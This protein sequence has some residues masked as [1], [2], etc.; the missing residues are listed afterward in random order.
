MKECLICAEELEED[1]LICTQCP[2]QLHFSCAFGTPV[3]NGRTRSMFQNGSF[4]CPVC[5]VSK[6]NDLILQC[7]S[8]NQKYIK[9]SN[10]TQRQPQDDAAPAEERNAAADDSEDML[11]V[12]DAEEVSVV[13]VSDVLNNTDCENDIYAESS[14]CLGGV[15]LTLGS[16]KYPSPPRRYV[17]DRS[18]THRQPRPAANIN[19]LPGL[20]R[21]SAQTAGQAQT[22]PDPTMAPP[23]KLCVEKSKQMLYRLGTLRRSPGHANTFIGGDSHLTKLD[24]KEVDPDDDQVRVRA[25]GGLCIISTVL[26]LLQFK[27]VLHKF[28]KV[29][30]VVG[31]NDALH[32]QDHC[33]DDQGKYLKLLYQ[34]SKRIFPHASI[35]IITPFSGINGISVPYLQNLEET[36]KFV[37][38]KM[39]VVRPPTMR[40][41][42]GIKGVHLSRAGRLAFINFLR[43]NFVKPKQRIFSR[44]SGRSTNTKPQADAPTA[45]VPTPKQHVASQHAN[46]GT[47][48]VP[49]TSVTD[50]NS[51]AQPSYNVCG[52]NQVH[53]Q[54]QSV[55]PDGVS[56]LNTCKPNPLYGHQVRQHDPLFGEHTVR[57]I[58][59]TV[60]NELIKQQQR[61]F[62]NHHPQ[63]W[64]GPFNY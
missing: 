22:L 47:L 40:D 61:M 25:V 11:S 16:P 44:E 46:H 59:A 30:W 60:A 56:V 34:E 51:R 9:A 31:T 50:I 17:Q 2:S 38:P 41:K 58:A 6:N 23:H 64:R 57:D 4:L 35:S 7:V 24:G 1:E 29:A 14:V 5:I 15:N 45:V 18:P 19:G 10:T 37:A 54:P 62:L 63:P 52:D 3:N 33:H 42:I 43:A 27:S 8:T 20:P 55:P 21:A 39:R 49:P 32:I 36:S 26:A 12:P 13:E 28:Q 48:T 53:Q